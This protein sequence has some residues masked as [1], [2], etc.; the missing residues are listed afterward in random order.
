[1]SQQFPEVQVWLQTLRVQ[2]SE[3]TARVEVVD[4]DVTAQLF[5]RVYEALRLT[6]FGFALHKDR[7]RKEE[8]VSSKS[9]QLRDCGLRHGD[10][11]YLSP[12]N[13][14][15]LFDQPTT[16]AEVLCIHSYWIQI[17]LHAHY[18]NQFD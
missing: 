3:G 4:T 6:T 12:V 13:G 17:C 5:E 7:Q 15:V 10:M 2:S 1:M 8:I 11:L 16:S 14:A 18:T 9:R